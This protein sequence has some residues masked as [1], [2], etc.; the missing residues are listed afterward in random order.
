[1][2][3]WLLFKDEM[4]G[5][6]KSN[7]MIVLW[8]G[9]PILS[10]LFHYFQPNMEEIPISS[11]VAILIASIGGTLASVML[12]TS[13]VNEKNRHVYDLFLIRPVKRH[14]I[15]I[16][17]FCSV[18]ICLIIAALIAIISGFLIDYFTISL[19]F[20]SVLRDTMESIAISFS[21]MAISCSIGVLIGILANSVALA[22]VLSIYVGNQL[23]LLSIL[24]SVLIK[25][26]D[27]LL[28]AS[29]LGISATSIIM[30]INI[31]IFNK[32]QF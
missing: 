10:I 22:A 15:L 14:N 28:F 19:P 21:A 27:P 32:K 5:F 6:Y 2:S 24:P 23:S 12:S 3:L 17:K 9:I 8:I 25:T 11:M 7:V 18:Y 1:M 13:I 4:K 30:F 26:I 31:F 20:E 16:A 29:L